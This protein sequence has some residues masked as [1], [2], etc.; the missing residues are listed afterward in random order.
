MVSAHCSDTQ[1]SNTLNWVASIHFPIAQIG[2]HIDASLSRQPL[3]K[4]ER[5]VRHAVNAA[6]RRRMPAGVCSYMDL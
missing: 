1:A 5:L 3:E 4:G 2:S 6:M